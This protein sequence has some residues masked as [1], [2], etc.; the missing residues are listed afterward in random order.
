MIRWCAICSRPT[1]A[2]VQPGPRTRKD[3]LVLA[4]RRAFILLAGLGPALVIAGTIEGNL[5]PSDAPAWVKIAVGLT[6]GVLLYSYLLLV[7]RKNPSP[8]DGEGPFPARAGTPKV[9]GGQG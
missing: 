8:L 6:S 4:A 3:A 9:G 2:L 5:S 7:G 1:W